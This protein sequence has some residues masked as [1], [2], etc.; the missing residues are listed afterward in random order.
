[1]NS[2][3]N[4]QTT[5][6]GTASLILNTIR[7]RGI[8]VGAY[9]DMAESVMQAIYQLAAVAQTVESKRRQ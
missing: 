6:T 9:G 8:A 7:G 2:T 1:M 4:R 3:R 5:L